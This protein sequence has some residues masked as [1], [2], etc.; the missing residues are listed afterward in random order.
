MI[1]PSEVHGR[2][3]AV[4]VWGVKPDGND[5]VVVFAGT[6]HWDRRHLG[7]VGDSG[8]ELLSLQPEWLDRLRHVDES[9]K[10]TLLGADLSISLNIGPLPE[11]ADKTK[12]V[13][14]G[15]RWPADDAS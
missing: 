1:H 5:D 11:G 12:F 6:V 9:L 10:E 13:K 2:R 15:L 3:L 14:T 7:L 8:D 4:V